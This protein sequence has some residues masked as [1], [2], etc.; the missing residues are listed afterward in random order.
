MHVAKPAQ[1]IDDSISGESNRIAEKII[2]NED[3]KL[4]ESSSELLQRSDPALDYS[5]GDKSCGSGSSVDGDSEESDTQ[6]DVI[7]QV[8]PPFKSCTDDLAMVK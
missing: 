8:A 4:E 5:F 2:R 3:S 1:S 7:I 6:R